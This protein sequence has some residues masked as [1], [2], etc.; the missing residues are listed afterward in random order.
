MYVI[1]CFCIA[2]LLK[3]R[4]DSCIISDMAWTCIVVIVIGILMEFIRYIRWQIDQKEKAHTQL[5]TKYAT[6]PVSIPKRYFSRLFSTSHILQTMFF[7]IQ[8]VLGYVLMLVFMTFSIWLG[9]AVCFG[10]DIDYIF[11]LYVF[12]ADK[13]MMMKMYFH[14]RIHEPILF[15]E[16]LPNDLT[17]YVF[18]CIGVAMIA[19]IYEII[20]CLRSRIE[21]MVN[22]QNLC[23]CELDATSSNGNVTLSNMSCA[24]NPENRTVELPFKSSHLMCYL[25]VLS[26]TVYFI[27]MFISYMLMM[28][29]MTY[30]VPIFL[31]LVLGHMMAFFFFVPITSVR[32]YEKLGNCCG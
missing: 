16:W 2:Y 14:F 27:Q 28:I 10:T 6:L 32:E 17:G 29:S 25:H 26:S 31:S 24:V 18:S 13:K 4:K 9:I 8:L 12:I 21:K 19:S 11:P 20:K 30:N 23:R 3:L 5:T 15:R 22:E 1:I 7:G